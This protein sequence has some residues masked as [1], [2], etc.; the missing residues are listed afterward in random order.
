[1]EENIFVIPFDQ[2]KDSETDFIPFLF[3]LSIY[4]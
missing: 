3:F 1:M 2:S 4:A